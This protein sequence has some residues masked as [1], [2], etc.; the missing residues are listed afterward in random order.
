MRA[1]AENLKNQGNSH[2][3]LGQFAK[4]IDLYSRAILMLPASPHFY[5]NRLD[6]EGGG[7]VCNANAIHLKLVA[8]LQSR[9]AAHIELKQYDQAIKDC[10]AAISL[11]PKYSKAYSRLG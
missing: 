10:Q 2:M 3:R 6:G 1:A 4:A 7:V 11:D 8:R 5:G 9:A